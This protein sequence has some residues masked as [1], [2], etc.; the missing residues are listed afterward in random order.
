MTPFG[1]MGVRSA[2]SIL[3]IAMSGGLVVLGSFNMDAVDEIKV[4]QFDLAQRF[5]LMVAF[6]ER[7]DH[8][9]HLVCQ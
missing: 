8:H 7:L 4:L 2:V 9:V 3:G 6:A 5:D 1:N